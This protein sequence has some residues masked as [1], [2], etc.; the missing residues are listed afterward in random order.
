MFLRPIQEKQNRS[1]G[2]W[3]DPTRTIGTQDSQEVPIKPPC[4]DHSQNWVSLFVPTSLGDS[5]SFPCHK[6]LAGSGV[7]SDEP[8][9]P[10]TKPVQLN[11]S[12]LL[13]VKFIPDL[14]TGKKLNRDFQYLYPDWVPFDM[15]L[16]PYYS[17]KMEHVQRQQIVSLRNHW[18]MKCICWHHFLPSITKCIYPNRAEKTHPACFLLFCAL[19]SRWLHLHF[20]LLRH[21]PSPC[22]LHLSRGISKVFTSNPSSRKDFRRQAPGLLSSSWNR[23]S[24]WP[25]ADHMHVYQRQICAGDLHQASCGSG[26]KVL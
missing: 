11:L 2:E 4:G 20:A 3:N 1:F 6:I 16:W 15:D 22:S 26:R 17:S 19:R 23:I 25:G 24:C 10:K 12:T 7:K 14:L 13:S 9:N 8:P 5:C 21:R 18:E